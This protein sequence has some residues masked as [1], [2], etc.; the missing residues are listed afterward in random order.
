V[1][2]MSRDET[3][4]RLEIH[5]GEPLQRSVREF[6]EQVGWNVD[7]RGIFEDAA[8]FEDLRP[9]GERYLDRCHARVRRHLPPGGRYLLDVASGPVQRD[10]FLAYSERH[11]YRVC[12]DLTMSAL[13]G[14]R[15][16]LGRHGLYV[17][18]DIA[19][20]PFRDDTFEGAVSLHTIYHVPAAQ[21]AGSFL[22]FFRVV[23]PGTAGVVVYSW[24]K[25]APLMF[26][27]DA[28][29]HKI[30]SIWRGLRRAAGTA[31]REPGLYFAPQ[32]PA[33]FR[34]EVAARIPAEITVWRSLSP[35]FQQ[36]F[37]PQ[38]RFGEWFLD[39]V[40]ALEERWPKAFGRWG[41]YP[42]LVL[43]KPAGR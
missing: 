37:V 34:R 30:A 2:S 3:P 11:Q 10:E 23:R 8:R 15:R 18:G 29:P 36:H 7:E 20:L 13:R 9:V 43:R 27:F 35:F 40:Y 25:H 41:N 14:A 28:L 12:V 1:R 38:N 5:E 17:V 22:E 19:R 6:Y 24:G 31:A 4:A 33:W 42:L 21:Q 39:R 16:R 32:S 26:L